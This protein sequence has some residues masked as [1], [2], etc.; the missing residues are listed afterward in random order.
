MPIA[1]CIVAPGLQK[2]TGDLIDAWSRE[3]GES[4]EHMTINIIPAIE[5]VGCPYAVMATLMLPSAWPSPKV[6][7]L[8][9]G[10]AKA[11]ASSYQVKE[12]Q[13]H[14]I[15]TIVDSGMVVERGQ[16]IVW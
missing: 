12:S 7:A 6:S 14:V 15:T 11:L 5:Q 1:N 2:G 9:L 10:L 4:P 8:Q 3:S 16:E 13:I